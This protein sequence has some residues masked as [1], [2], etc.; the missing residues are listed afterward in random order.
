MRW[1]WPDRTDASLWRAN[2][3][4]PAKA[5]RQVGK[6]V[7]KTAGKVAGTSGDVAAGAAEVVT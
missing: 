5:L 7:G 6:N 1:K 3:Q 2:T 4:E